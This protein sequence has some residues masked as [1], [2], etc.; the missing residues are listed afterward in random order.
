EK[1]QQ[2]AERQE[3]PCPKRAFGL[4]K[5]E[6]HAE[7]RE[8]E[9]QRADRIEHS[10][11]LPKIALGARNQRAWEPQPAENK[12]GDPDRHIDEEGQPP[13]EIRAAELDQETTKRR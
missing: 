6:K 8:G 4:D 12:D 3:Q 1:E 11:R 9:K 13:A 7:D 10:Q 5:G 2:K